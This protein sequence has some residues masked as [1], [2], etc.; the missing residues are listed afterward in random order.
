MYMYLLAALIALT[1]NAGFTIMFYDELFSSFDLT[2]NKTFIEKTAVTS[3]VLF[4]S[5]L[6]ILELSFIL[7]LIA[8]N[9]LKIWDNKI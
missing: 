6:W 8:T 1:V 2:P 4:I 7:A 9:R 3:L 5:L